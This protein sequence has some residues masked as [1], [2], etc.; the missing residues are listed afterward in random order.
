VLIDWQIS[1]YCS[2]VI[3][4]VYFIFICTDRQLRA[5]H[6]D[7]LLNIYHHSLK[8]LLDHLGG[9][10]MTQFPFTAFLRHLKKFGKFG[11]VMATM[12]LPML[13]TKNEELMD[14]DY[15]AEKMVNPDP[16][17]MEKLMKE[18]MEKSSGYQTSVKRMREVFEDAIKYGYL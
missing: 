12:I 5:K 4:L 7:E 16:A 18:Y 15:M 1:R 17:E 10:T 6:Y 13:Q 8:E 14:M 9:D 2:P 11:V 3:D